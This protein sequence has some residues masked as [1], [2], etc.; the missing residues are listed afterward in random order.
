MADDSVKH[1][2]M[3]YGW[4][5]N[6]VANL[7]RVVNLIEDSSTWL[8]LSLT[9][10]ML[11]PHAKVRNDLY[12]DLL[13]KAYKKDEDGNIV[14]VKK[15]LV[16]ENGVVIKRTNT[17]SSGKDVEEI[18]MVDDPVIEY[19]EKFKVKIKELDSKTVEIAWKDTIPYK[20]IAQ[21]PI[22]YKIIQHELLDRVL[23][24]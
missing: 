8:V 11:E 6:M 9:L 16:D 10:K 13:K 18:V 17:N 15:P 3:E 7:N 2:K 4:I 20:D 5:A 21:F 19:P 23:R 1:E 14:M 22:G 24:R 12:E